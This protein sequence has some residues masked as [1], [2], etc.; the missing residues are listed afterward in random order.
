MVLACIFNS[1]YVVRFSVSVL[2]YAHFA[3]TVRV[4]ARL[5]EMPHNFTIFIPYGRDV[6]RRKVKVR[7]VTSHEGT[8]GEE[9]YSSILFLTSALDEN[10]WSA[11]RPD[12]FTFGKETRYPL[13]RRLSGPQGRCR[14]ARKTSPPPQTG[15]RSWTVQPV[16]NRY[17]DYTVPDHC[18]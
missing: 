7:P 4:P 2:E 15:I 18:P 17:A 3:W 10:G 8:A 14:R 9:R 16:G 6:D 11:P 13:C 5:N 12:R 1:V